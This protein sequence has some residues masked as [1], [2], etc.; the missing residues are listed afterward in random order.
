MR[1]SKLK[2]KRQ[3]KQVN[4]PL[5]LTEVKLSKLET[6]VLA[7]GLTFVCGPPNRNVWSKALDELKVNFE[8][9]MNEVWDKAVTETRLNRK[10]RY[11]NKVLSLP[12][13]Y[14]HPV[15]VVQ[16]GGRKIPG[17]KEKVKTFGENLRKGK[18]RK[19]KQNIT[20]EEF[21]ALL[22]LK[23]RDDIVIKKADK[24][25]MI[26]IWRADNY[27]L[28]GLR[29]L[30]D[31]ETYSIVADSA[32]ALLKTQ[33]RSRDLILELY[34]NY[35]RSTKK[36]LNETLRGGILTAA[37][38]DHFVVFTSRIPAM[39]FLPK[40]HKGLN[41]DTGTWKGRPV[42]SGCAAPTRPIDMICT[43]LL[44]PLLKLLEERL[45]DTTDFLNKITN[46]PDL[47]PVGASIFSLDVE[48]LYP[49]IPQKEAARVVAD[50]F[51]ERKDEIAEE[52]KDAG[53]S[54]PPRKELLERCLLHVMEDTLLA[55]DGITYRQIKGTAIGASVSV[56]VAEVFVHQVFE[57]HRIKYRPAPMVYFRYIDDI[58]GVMMGGESEVSKFHAWANTVH[59][60]L[61]F[62][63]ESHTKALPFLDTKV[64]IDDTRKLQTDIFYKE[65]NLHTYLLF[66][67]CHPMSLKKSLPYSLGIRVKRIVSDA[68]NLKS[69]LEDLWTFFKNRGYPPDIMEKASAKLE[70]LRREDLLKKSRNKAALT[71]IIL[72]CLFL[73]DISRLIQS[74]INAVWE[75]FCESFMDH[76]AKEYFPIDPP[77]IA[78]RKNKSLSDHLVRA[79]FPAPRKS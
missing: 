79:K 30:R 25:G 43:A 61:K 21:K 55:F 35:A 4:T 20:A 12:Y 9:K 2:E 63:V 3:M 75:W 6:Q 67:S 52:L 70:P 60:N 66:T 11:I 45:T 72:P 36:G 32:G 59:V 33:Q 1:D 29:Q 13:K 44:T 27:R 51:Y 48:A 50:F 57:S 17:L 74:E 77:M 8:R 65:S 71:R 46:Y 14:L 15:R 54:R 69:A 73:P 38:R 5:V 28:E 24:G 16:K 26:C 56:A 62:T 41:V 78:W 40:V 23:K 53:V 58:F 19:F 10:R 68:S 64:Y 76:P 49:S 31:E 42:L 39:Y 18:H 34:N 22:S 7:K 37:V 47:V